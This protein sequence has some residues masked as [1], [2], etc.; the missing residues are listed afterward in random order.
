MKPTKI[1][2]FNTIK[3]LSTGTNFQ[4]ITDLILQPEMMLAAVELLFLLYPGCTLPVHFTI[5]REN[6]FRVLQFESFN[7]LN[8]SASAKL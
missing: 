4:S 1:R 2:I 5:G 7:P 8:N 6:S 3:N